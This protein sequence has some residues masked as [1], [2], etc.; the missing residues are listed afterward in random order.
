MK[1]YFNFEKFANWALVSVALC[2]WLSGA[3]PNYSTV[4]LASAAFI[5]ALVFA[6]HLKKNSLSQTINNQDHHSILKRERSHE[7]SSPRGKTQQSEEYFDQYVVALQ[8]S[9]VIRD[10]KSSAWQS[11]DTDASCRGPIYDLTPLVGDN[12]SVKVGL[13]RIDVK[14]GRATIKMSDHHGRSRF[15]TEDSKVDM[16]L[17]PENYLAGDLSNWGDTVN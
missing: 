13:V 7:I 4:I 16:V 12:Y 6:L 3:Y 11:W 1:K 2:A 14:D 5:G 9:L 15:R 17:S 10:K 8:R